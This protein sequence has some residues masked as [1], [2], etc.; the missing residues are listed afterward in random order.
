MRLEELTKYDPITVQCHDNPDADAIAAGYAL[1]RYFE[2]VG[3]RVRLV[4]GG[5]NKI[6][7]PNLLLMLERLQI[8]I[9][10]IEDAAAFAAGEP[11]GKLPGLLITVDCQYGAGNVTKLPAKQVAIIDHHQIEVENV[12][13][14]E[15]NSH[16]GSCSTLVWRLLVEA[17]CPVQDTVLG[18]ALY[19]GLF[20]DTNQFAEIYDPLDRDMREAVPYEKSLITLFRNSN[21]SLQ[22][23]EVAGVAMIRYIYNDDY[24]Y[25]IIKSKPCDPNILGLI[26]DFLIQVAEVHSCVVYNETGDG[27][28]F[29]VRSCVKEV[30]A[31]ELAH[32][33]AEGVGSGGGHREKAGGF[34]NLALYEEAYP[35][36]HS[37]AF[38]SERLNDYFDN[39]EIIFAQSYDIDISDM[40]VYI[41]KPV[42]LGYVKAVD[43]LP[44]DTP[45]TVRT[46][47]GDLDI[48]VEEDL[49]IMVG[50]QGEV[51]PNRLSRFEKNYQ[52]TAKP[53]REYENHGRNALFYE[54]TIHNRATGEVMKL[55]DHAKI[56]IADGGTRVFT[57]ELTKR[58]KVF[59]AWDKDKY[60]LG[61]PGDYLVVRCEDRQDIYVVE[62]EIFFKTFERETGT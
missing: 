56:C 26:S 18:T 19:Y 14:S 44:V 16:V 30:Q 12:E 38:F 49:I 25:A 2:F 20:T 21:L 22:E 53:Y 58:V 61:R 29:S 9:T 51:Y 40:S 52:V 46:L 5:R 6:Q 50:I 43:M 60:M 11:E 36:L 54:P 42:T 47:E 41:K 10:Y 1:C 31:N 4:Y 34:I 39:C 35:T 8:P 27:Y 32:F 62:R 48:R 17:G 24:C 37:E 23:L 3:R 33:L 59:T 55:I 13:L 28:K 15:I 45:I 57:R 7:K